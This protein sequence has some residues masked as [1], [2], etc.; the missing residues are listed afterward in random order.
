MENV[1]RVVTLPSVRP[2]SSSDD[3]PPTAAD[4]TLS[5]LL[6]FEALLDRLFA[7]FIS[8]GPAEVDEALDEALAEIGEFVGAD[9]S[10][11]I[12]CDKASELSWMT[13]EW[14]REGVEPSIDVEQAVP[15]SAAP[16]QH[17][18]L[19]RFE[20]NEI[21]DVASLPSDWD[22][23]RDYLQSQGITAI[24]EVPF[25]VEGDLDGVIG[26][27]CVRGAVPWRPGD[28]TALRALATLLGQVLSRAA[29]ERALTR[30]LN[31]LNTIFEEAPVSLLLIDRRGVI[32]QANE[33]TASILGVVRDEVI[34]EEVRRFV[35]PED[36]R[37]H[38][39]YWANLIAPS[40]GPGGRAAVS[41]TELRL[42]TP[43]GDRW[44]RASTTPTRRGDGTVTYFTVHLVDIDEARRTEAAL[45]HSES[46]FGNLLDNLPDV[47]IRLNAQM[48]V[49]FSNP[50]ARELRDHIA[51]TGGPM[52]DSG[53]PLPPDEHLAVYEAALYSSIEEQTPKAAEHLLGAGPNQAWYETIF[54]PEL[55]ASGDLESLLLVGRDVTTR[56]A[57]AEV[58]AH[59]ATHDRLTGLPNRMLFL[60]LLE[61]STSSLREGSSL[62]VL[63]F[64]LD[65]FKVVND[66]LGHAAGDQLLVRL[67][68]RLRSALRPGDVLA[69]LGGDEFT[70]LISDV[71]EEGAL[72]V[73]DRLQASL[74]MPVDVDGRE[75][76]MS[77][78]IGVVVT[79][80]AE[81]SNDL[82]RWADAA[83][84]RAKDMGRNRIA[85]F[86]DAL[87]AE[88]TE[89]LERDQMLRTALD[90][91]ELEVWFQPEVH[92]ATGRVIGAEALV[93]WC[94]PKHG[95]LAAGEFVPLA[96]E[97]G[98]IIP[99]GHWVMDTACAQVTRWLTDGTVDERFV[100][101]VNLSARQLELPTLVA[102]VSELLERSGLPPRQLCLEITETALMRDVDMALRVLT[103]LHEVGVSL[104]VDDF[105]TGYSSLSF[106]KRFP[107]DVLK[108]DRSFVDGLPDDH[109]D[110]AIVSTILQLAASLG[111]STTAEGVETEEQHHA[112]VELGCPTAQGYLFAR[113]LP[114]PEFEQLVRCEAASAGDA[115]AAPDREL[116][117][118]VASQSSSS[119]RRSSATG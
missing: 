28:A 8:V 96:E 70:V 53:W 12:N 117:G 20:V 5:R 101:R 36:W 86:D 72:I 52:T 65:R 84:Y 90:R 92:L 7:R 18:Q 118:S 63:F 102:E 42:T 33:S 2:S 113:P 9:R 59:Q 64:D 69:R 77:A 15:F 45:E 104:A 85:M 105:G 57:Q 24:L 22:Q 49:D 13:H 11:I 87:R 66:S 100:L 95:R 60:D 112:L 56:R 32:L 25:S 21:R 81:D 30:S 79:D 73:A 44:H 116:V 107:L 111:L 67:A 108:I 38:L 48:Q 89:R 19:A 4:P 41:T 91:D 29:A 93:R 62:A 98:M 83:M 68:D 16:K 40:S 109:D 35:H 106:L 94:H 39:P 114:I 50:A 88:V 82:L 54:V 1:A 99:I 3:H 75:F 46:R 58:L 119:E 37:A 103:E 61:R 97:N 55:N 80:V 110:V 115:H 78:S 17:E 71:D 6:G 76:L 74:Q 34:G 10:Y 14:C 47:I 26:F 51:A 31:E 27:D 23:D 43:R